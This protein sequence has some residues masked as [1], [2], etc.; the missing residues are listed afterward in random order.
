MNMTTQLT[1]D[2]AFLNIATV[3]SATQGKNLRVVLKSF[4]FQQQI[5]PNSSR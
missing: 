1:A 4:L 2:S 3:F 5:Q